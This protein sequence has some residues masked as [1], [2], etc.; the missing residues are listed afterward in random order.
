MKFRVGLIA[1]LF[2]MVPYVANAVLMHE[3]YEYFD[4]PKGLGLGRAMTAKAINEDAL[5][6]NSAGLGNVD[7]WWLNFNFGA[8]I[9]AKVIDFIQAVP[10]F[11]SI[12]E[13][14]E[15]SQ[16]YQIVEE[17]L[18]L[19][20]TNENIHA[21]F[22]L[23]SSLIIPVWKGAIAGGINVHALSLNAKIAPD[24]FNGLSLRDTSDLSVNLGYGFRLP[25][26]ENVRFGVMSKTMY[27]FG[28]N[29]DF[30][31]SRLLNEKIDQNI[32]KEGFGFDFDI[33]VQYFT[34]MFDIPY[35]PDFKAKG[36]IN[37]HNILNQKFGTSFNLVNQNANDPPPALARKMS[38]G[39]AIEFTKFWKFVNEVSFDIRNIGVGNGT[40]W[41]R[42]HMGYEC[43][44]KFASWF[45]G[46]LYANVH[47][48]GL[49]A[50]LFGKLWVFTLDVGTY[51]VT[52]GIYP[53]QGAD[54]RY[55]VQLG[56]NI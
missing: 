13:T 22:Y 42:F 44:A 33:G 37:F 45:V 4:T 29:E 40:F 8:T 41:K 28:L 50:G 32:A 55:Y 14:A 27:R 31:F 9:S 17:L 20:A 21:R 26:H 38:I 52:T 56:I 25:W 3:Y 16:T 36:G 23:S 51:D 19:K 18:K 11:T 34:R 47:Q 5:Y 48:G 54:R 7:D 39:A 12:E 35:F 49:G 30:T 46:A 53:G 6:Y 43:R 10:N 24:M 2:L 15:K 1:L